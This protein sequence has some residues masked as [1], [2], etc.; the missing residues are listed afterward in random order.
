MGDEIQGVV[1]HH[2]ATASTKSGILQTPTDPFR[3]AILPNG[4]SIYIVA[5]AP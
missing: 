4:S 5:F 1:F 3:L 2:S